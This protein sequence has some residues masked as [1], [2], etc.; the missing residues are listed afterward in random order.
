MSAPFTKLHN[1]SNCRTS[2]YFSQT[3]PIPSYA[4]II[5]VGFLQKTKIGPRSWVFAENKFFQKSIE[6]FAGI[7]EMLLTAENFCGPYVFGKISMTLFLLK[8]ICILIFFGVLS[9]FIFPLYI[10]TILLL[11]YF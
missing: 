10:V 4:V 2:Y 6:T 11:L 5:L 3:K 9:N 8:F 7:D 1:W